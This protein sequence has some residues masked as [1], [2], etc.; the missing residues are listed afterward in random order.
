MVRKSLDLKG[1]LW[2]V[3]PSTGCN[4]SSMHRG[5]LLLS[6]P[7][8]WQPCK[9]FCI[10][11]AFLVCLAEVPGLIR[12]TLLAWEFTNVK[13]SSQTPC[14]EVQKAVQRNKVQN[15]GEIWHF[16]NVP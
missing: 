12:H 2:C 14:L 6:L 5:Q 16:E 1:M 11:S 7:A 8:T 10:A 4:M 9:T 3:L 15:C 13:S